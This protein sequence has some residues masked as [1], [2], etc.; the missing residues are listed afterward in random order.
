MQV[1]EGTFGIN[2]S[3]VIAADQS[4]TAE[5]EFLADTLKQTADVNA[6]YNEEGNILFIQVPKTDI[7]DEGYTLEVLP[8]RIVIKAS[9]EEGAAVFAVT[10]GT[11]D[12]SAT[13]KIQEQ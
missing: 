1:T 7:K 2:K 10:S 11:Y 4:F 5:A 6:A 8:N 9:S 3:I 13:I 12:F